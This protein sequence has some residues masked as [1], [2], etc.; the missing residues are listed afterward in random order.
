[1]CGF[2]INP[3]AFDELPVDRINITHHEAVRR[4]IRGVGPLFRVSPLNVQLDAIARYASV[5]GFFWRVLKQQ[6]EPDIAVE[7]R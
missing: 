4:A 3:A 7:L 5:L 1:M 2:R 6:R